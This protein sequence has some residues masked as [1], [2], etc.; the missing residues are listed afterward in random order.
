MKTT[1]QVLYGLLLSAMGIVVCVYLGFLFNSQ[2]NWIT[3]IAVLLLLAITQWIAIFVVRRRIALQVFFGLLMCMATSTSLLYS[4]FPIFWE[5]QD[6]QA[7]VYPIT[8]RSDI[9]FV[10]LLFI[11][12]GIAF[13]AFHWIRTFHMSRR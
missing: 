9:M 6:G 4:G 11:T 13:L 12:Q 8:W 1:L 7:G 5:H 10:L 2:P 3:V